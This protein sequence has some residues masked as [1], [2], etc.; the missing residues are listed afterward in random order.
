MEVWKRSYTVEALKIVLIRCCVSGTA[1]IPSTREE[2]F[3][4][5]GC[6]ERVPHRGG[7]KYCADPLLGIRHHNDS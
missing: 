1:M 3:L 7:I 5:C 4:H 6:M 2:K